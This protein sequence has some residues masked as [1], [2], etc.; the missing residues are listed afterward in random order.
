MRRL[1]PAASALAL[2]LSTASASASSYEILFD[3]PVRVG[4]APVTGVTVGPDTALFGT[5]S[6]GS[7]VGGLP[8]GAIYRLK[9]PTPPA[10]AWE[11]NIFY[12]IPTG[13]GTPQGEITYGR[14]GHL[15]GS[16]GALFHDIGFVFDLYRI[17][18]TTDGWEIC[19][20]RGFGGSAGDGPKAALTQAPDGSLYGT[21]DGDYYHTGLGTVF[22]MTPRGGGEWAS[23]EIQI[24]SSA[25]GGHP[26]SKPVVDGL[27]RV[28]G[29]I[30][31]SANGTGGAVFVM[32][33][34]KTAGGAWTYTEIQ[35]FAAGRLEAGVIR[36]PAGRL[37]GVARD[38]GAYGQGFVYEISPPRAKKKTW[39]AR[40]LTNFPG[41]ANGGAPLAELI[42]G[43]DGTLYG[44]TSLGGGGFA[45]TVFALKPPA[46][47][48]GPWSR[49]TLHA[50]AGSPDGAEPIGRLSFDID[51]S[52]LGT[53][54]RGGA[55]DAGTV[56]RIRP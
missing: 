49:T 41:G 2:V 6:V 29:T 19:W 7:I 23:E 25:T 37:Y 40:V 21:S 43:R 16:T 15:Y 51:G 12:D 8:E 9:R 31:E 46:S 33:P 20:I 24:F 44:T 32:T 5:T 42:R 54:R 38:G 34:P 13:H 35:R 4:F 53:T 11:Y 22:R 50:F 52:I 56:F 55:N 36:G 45:G 26:S 27:G 47:G 14:D 18:G 17:P 1:L 3:F 30:R 28:F 39:T 10:T 48:I